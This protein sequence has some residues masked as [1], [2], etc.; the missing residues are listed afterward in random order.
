MKPLQHSAPNTPLYI[1][2]PPRTYYARTPR[3]LTAKELRMW[4]LLSRAVHLFP[5]ALF[6]PFHV[7]QLGSLFVSF[8]S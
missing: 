8:Q 6:L 3:P 2:Y 4:P 7:P 1:A 5:V